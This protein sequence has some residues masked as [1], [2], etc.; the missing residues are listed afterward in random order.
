MKRK[1][2]Y[3][4]ILTLFFWG[5]LAVF[6]KAEE[7][8]LDYEG[9]VVVDSDLDGLTDL[10]EEKIFR[11]DPKN[12]DTDGD[13]FLDGAEVIGGSNYLDNSDPRVKETI[14]YSYPENEDTLWSWYLSRAGGIVAILLVYVSIFFGSI[15]R[16]PFLQKFI[17]PLAS[18]EIHKW[19]SVQAFIFVIIHAVV[20]LWDKYI[21]FSPKDIFVPFASVYN[22]AMVTLGVLGMYA[23]LALILTSYFKKYISYAVWRA[24][25]FLNIF[26][27][28][29][30]FVHAFE[31]GTD[32][33]NLA[34]QETA[35]IL[36]GILAAVLL[37]NL[38]FH[39]K[40]FILLKF[41]REKNE[42]LH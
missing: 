41:R 29:A 2:F 37:I 6:V 3:S 39:L 25:H 9:N 16:L 14:T 8:E 26:V 30:A 34:V 38:S 4:L 15:I 17:E 18:L 20:L 21:G 42:D 40:S 31:M 32:F 27:F 19:I 12:P 1:I 35:I 24:V 7:N 36:T 28:A 33:K 5:A 10:G 23:I 11:T 13:G 22:P